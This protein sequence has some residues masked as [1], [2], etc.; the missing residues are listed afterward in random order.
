MFRTVSL[1]AFAQLTYRKSL[2]DI[3]AFLCP[4][5]SKLYHMVFVV[6]YHE[7]ALSIQTKNETGESMPTLLKY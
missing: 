1:L 4:I 2:H 5:H 7:I 3:E 6:K